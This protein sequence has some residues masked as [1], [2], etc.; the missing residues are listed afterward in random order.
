MTT[1]LRIAA[2]GFG[3]AVLATSV[4]W[5][6]QMAGLPDRDTAIQ[7]WLHLGDEVAER[8]AVHPLV[9]LITGQSNAGNYGSG[10]RPTAA[11]GIFN[12]YRS[13]LYRARDPLLG[14]DALG[15]SQW[16]PFAES[17]RLQQS[18]SRPIVLALAVRGGQR[19]YAWNEGQ[20]MRSEVTAR[21]ADLKSLRLQPDYVLWQQGETDAWPL[22]TSADTYAGVLRDFIGFLRK[23][24]V[25]APVLVAQATRT[26]SSGPFQ[27]IREAQLSMADPSRLVFRGPD[28]DSLGPAFRRDGV[29]F[30]ASGISAIASLWVEAVK[31]VEQSISPAGKAAGSPAPRPSSPYRTY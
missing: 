6:P 29:H 16:I 3:L 24:G 25:S 7:W 21:L 8:S 4:V 23:A 13:K 20:P 10:E 26:P 19:I 18:P 28:A 1:R 5:N 27:P 15:V 11:T 31:L 12:A 22:R 14:S 30:N 9:F 2:I 17:L